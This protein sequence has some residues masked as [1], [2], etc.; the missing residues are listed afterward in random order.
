ML[1][2]SSQNQHHI[3]G[4]WIDTHK[5]ELETTHIDFNILLT[6]D[7]CFVWGNISKIENVAD[8]K[9]WRCMTQNIESE[10]SMSTVLC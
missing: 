9:N 4:V 8:L 7:I 2:D 3:A 6:S 10:T 1:V 5:K